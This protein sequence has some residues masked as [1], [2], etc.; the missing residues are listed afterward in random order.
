M[1]L[2]VYVYLIQL[3]C[4][5]FPLTISLLGAQL[6]MHKED[7]LSNSDR[8]NFYLEAMSEELS[9]PFE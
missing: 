2:L 7:T 3:I 9:E 1:F 5:G 6:E 8:W 4:L